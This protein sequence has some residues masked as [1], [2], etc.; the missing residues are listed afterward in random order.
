MAPDQSQTRV[1]YCR[2][3]QAPIFWATF[4]ASGKRA[5]IDLDP[6]EGGNLVIVGH[7]YTGPLVDVVRDTGQLLPDERPHY[8]NHWA[9]CTAPPPRRR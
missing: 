6:V 7:D 4:Q 2:T 5:P 1:A 9:T 3:C 8:L